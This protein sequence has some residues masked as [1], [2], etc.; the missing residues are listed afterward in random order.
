MS[1]SRLTTASKKGRGDQTSKQNPRLLEGEMTP[2]RWNGGRQEEG[3]EA[4]P[5]NRIVI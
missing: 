4:S 5:P 3:D 2:I 1:S